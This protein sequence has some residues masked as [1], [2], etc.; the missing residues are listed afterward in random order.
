M[1]IEVDEHPHLRRP[2]Y[3]LDNYVLDRHNMSI[4]NMSIHIIPTKKN[5]IHI[6]GPFAIGVQI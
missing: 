4:H 6:D 3:I 5:T 1:R 2:V